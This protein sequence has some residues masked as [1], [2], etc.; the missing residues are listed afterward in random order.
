[1]KLKNWDTMLTGDAAF[2]LKEVGRLI[3][4]ARKRRGLS[5]LGLANRARVDRRTVAQLEAGHPGVSIG[6]FFQVL[7]LFNLA[8]GI[9]EFLKPENDIETAA[10]K[11]RRIRKRQKITRAIPEEEVNF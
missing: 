1:M 11:V 6:L 7:S 10:A 9:E 5:L 8:K 2:L 3:A 4:E